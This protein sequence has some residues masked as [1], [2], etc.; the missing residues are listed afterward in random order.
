MHWNKEYFQPLLLLNYNLLPD[1]PGRL[2]KNILKNNAQDSF[3]EYEN[4]MNDFD[5]SSKGYVLIHWD[6]F[7]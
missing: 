6:I 7:H 1:L 3:P 2:T 5:I 4:K